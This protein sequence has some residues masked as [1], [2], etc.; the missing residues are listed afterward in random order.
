[1]KRFNEIHKSDT[2]LR[3]DTYEWIL[4]QFE[5]GNLTPEEEGDI[6]Q[7]LAYLELVK[8]GTDNLPKELQEEFYHNILLQMEDGSFPP[9][10]IF[11]SAVYFN[12]TRIGIDTS[13]MREV[14]NSS[15]FLSEEIEQSIL[16]E[17]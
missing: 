1:M 3:A 2:V 13:E 14:I 12:L 9:D 7:N 17:L 6:L 5:K 4:L 16:Q 10:I 15:P 11:W 8:K